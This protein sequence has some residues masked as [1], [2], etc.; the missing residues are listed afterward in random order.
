MSCSHSPS[1]FEAVE[2]GLVVDGVGVLFD[3]GARCEAGD[4]RINLSIVLIGDL[5]ERSSELLCI[6]YVAFDYFCS[7]E[8]GAVEEFAFVTFYLF[9]VADQGYGFVSL[10]DRFANCG[11]ADVAGRSGDD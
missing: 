11:F 1:G 2:R 10:A 4:H 5:F 3:T 7:L 9:L 6:A 8:E